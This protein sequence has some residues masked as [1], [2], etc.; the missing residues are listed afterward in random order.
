MDDKDYIWTRISNFLKHRVVVDGIQSDLISVDSGV[1][2]GTVL[3]LILV[4]A[5]HFF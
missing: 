5:T 1:P 3:D 4:F 2:Q